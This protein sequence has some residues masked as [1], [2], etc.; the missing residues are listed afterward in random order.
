MVLTFNVTGK[1]NAIEYKGKRVLI[2]KNGGKT[3]KYSDNQ[4]YRNITNRFKILLNKAIAEHNNTV[5][6]VVEQKRKSEGVA[7]NDDLTKNI[8]SNV[9]E[10]IETKSDEY[11]T[12]TTR[13]ANKISI[14]TQ[15]VRELSGYLNPIGS[16]D[17]TIATLLQLT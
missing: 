17:A 11:Q 3:F 4:R 5:D 9:K 10:K 8:I 7:P 12:I 14:D 2:S 6:G 13:E 16:S 1:A 15:E